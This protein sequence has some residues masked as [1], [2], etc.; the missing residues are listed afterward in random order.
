MD[1]LFIFLCSQ[2]LWTKKLIQQG[3]TVTLIA[4]QAV[5]KRQTGLRLLSTH[6]LRA[7]IGIAHPF[8]TLQQTRTQDAQ[9]GF[10]NHNLPQDQENE[11]CDTK[12]N[13]Q[14]TNELPVLIVFP[15]ML[16]NLLATKNR[17]YN[18]HE[19]RKAEKASSLIR[20]IATVIGS[21]G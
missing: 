15:L 9:Y 8:G 19:I 17:N 7:G 11:I 4:T 13:L 12:H 1:R 21:I 2:R 18:C 16:V 14:R 10:Q 20:L 6:H 5:Y 3:E